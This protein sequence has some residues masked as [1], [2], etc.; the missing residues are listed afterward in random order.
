MISRGTSIGAG[1]P[2]WRCQDCGIKHDQKRQVNAQAFG[3][4]SPALDFR[5]G[6]WGGRFG[7]R[8]R[9]A[10]RAIVPYTTARHP[11]ES[12][13]LISQSAPTLQR[14][15]LSIKGGVD[16]RVERWIPAFAGMTAV[17]FGT[18]RLAPAVQ[19]LQCHSRAGGNLVVGEGR[20]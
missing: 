15:R 2:E 19:Q 18:P 20:Y 14:L 5:V 8:G 10:G 13:D 17:G 7:W 3:R 4:H 1:F 9:S 12:R 11:G 16:V 6:T